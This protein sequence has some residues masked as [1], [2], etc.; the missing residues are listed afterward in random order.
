MKFSY[1]I[2]VENDLSEKSLKST[3]CF[4]TRNDQR[5]ITSK[6]SEIK[7]VDDANL[8]IYDL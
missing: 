1:R 2:H 5:K 7:V 6:K 8:Y 3:T 4:M